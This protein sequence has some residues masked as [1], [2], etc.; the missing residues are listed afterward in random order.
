M[1]IYL[2]QNFGKRENSTRAPALDTG[3]KFECVLK[4][5]TS[6]TDPVIEI[7]ERILNYYYKYNYAYI[8][9]FN[10]Y[11]FIDNIRSEGMLWVYSLRVDVL[12]SYV[13]NIEKHGFYILRSSTEYNGKIQ[14]TY[15]PVSFDHKT[16]IQRYPTMWASGTGSQDGDMNIENGVFVL[17]IVAV[18][19]SNSKGSYGSIKYYAFEQSEFYQL[20][21]YLLTNVIDD[22]VNGFNAADATISLQKSLINPLSYI[23]SCIWLP[24][25]YDSFSGTEQTSI[26]VWDWTVS[27]C[28]AKLITSDIPYRTLVQFFSRHNHPQISR[29]AYMNASPYTRTTICYP[30][31]GVFELDTAAMINS[32]DIV[33]TCKVDLISGLGTF[34]ISAFT[35]PEYQLNGSDTG[36]N[37]LNRVKAQIGVPI[38]LSEIGYDYSNVLASAVGIG[39]EALLS[40]FGNAMNSTISNAIS[41]IGTAANAMRTKASSLGS[42]GGFSELSGWAV[43]YEDYYLAVDED[44]AHLGRPLCKIRTLQQLGHGYYIVRDGD[45]ELKQALFSEMQQIKTYLESGIF[46]E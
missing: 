31:F 12:A 9:D 17:G 10:R 11:Y 29:G 4:E 39:A 8:P 5:P 22:G 34:D 43:L 3:N 15:Y 44:L 37:L 19:A 46:Y 24:I 40:N 7:R 28:T 1:E 30:P 45:L 20:V 6:V 42:N 25:G 18:P 16:L 21:H 41:Q 27:S 35:D 13:S 38:Q 33:T 32:G 2:F 14:D 36:Y 26:S 23:K